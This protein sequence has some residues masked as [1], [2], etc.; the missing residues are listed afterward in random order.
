MNPGRLLHPLA[1][2]RPPPGPPAPVPPTPLTPPA[3]HLI[4]AK[5][6]SI[7]PLKPPTTGFAAIKPATN[8]STA[9]STLS[10][11]G[12]SRKPFPQ[13]P[14]NRDCQLRI[15]AAL[16]AAHLIAAKPSKY[17]DSMSPKQGFAAIKPA[18]SGTS[19]STS[20]K[21]TNRLQ[22]PCIHPSRPETPLRTS[23][24][25]VH[26]KSANRGFSPK[27]H[28]EETNH[29]VCQLRKCAV[30]P[31]SEATSPTPPLRTYAATIAAHLIA[32]KSSNLPDF[33][34]PKHGFAAIKHAKLTNPLPPSLLHII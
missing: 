21:L 10:K 13:D 11:R 15:S 2:R 19:R 4:A 22:E 30:H 17:P 12:F 23:P 20:S 18:I 16:P 8:R 32:A 34:S 33:M 5:P 3:A 24:A 27:P 9:R 25:A 14:T 7:P 29:G 28:L 31:V 6:R 26:C 1:L